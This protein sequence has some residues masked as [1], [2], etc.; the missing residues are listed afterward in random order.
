MVLSN[1]FQRIDKR[2]K[3]LAKAYDAARIVGSACEA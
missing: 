3:E 1:L 2:A